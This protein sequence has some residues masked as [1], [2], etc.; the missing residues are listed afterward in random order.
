MRVLLLVLAIS[1]NAQSLK[2]GAVGDIIFH[3]QLQRQ[4]YCLDQETS[5]CT[6]SR[7]NP[8]FQFMWQFVEEHLEAMDIMFGNLEGPSNPNL[9]YRTNGEQE[10]SKVFNFDQEAINQLAASG[11]DILTVANNHSLDAGQSGV[12]ET[13]DA[14]ENVGIEPIGLQRSGQRGFSR[15]VRIVEENGI[16]LAFISCAGFLNGNTDTR[17]Q[18]AKCYSQDSQT[19]NDPGNPEILNLIEE[20]SNRRDINGVIFS[21][22]WGIDAGTYDRQASSTAAQGRRVHNSQ[23]R[24]ASAAIQR[25]ADLILGHHPHV[26]QE[27]ERTTEGKYIFYSL[28]N[29]VSNQTPWNW[30]DRPNVTD[31]YLKRFQKRTSVI[32]YLDIRL[33]RNRKIR[34]NQFKVLPIYMKARSEFENRFNMALGESVYRMRTLIPA[35]PYEDFLNTNTTSVN[36]GNIQ[37]GSYTFQENL[38]LT[39]QLVRHSFPEQ[40]WITNE[41]YEN[42]NLIFSRGRN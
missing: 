2:L 40:Y 11:F 38:F 22:H 37:R 6:G 29:F 17:N 20:Y 26:L 13:I 4:A 23:R 8:D 36:S 33:N 18:I 15:T 9:P 3:G 10:S 1:A 25:G 41:E 28:G 14:L 5:Y 32:L 35:I 27:Y 12:S 19:P 7:S 39:R 31:R 16:R 42:P 34:V 24:L 30:M 21:P